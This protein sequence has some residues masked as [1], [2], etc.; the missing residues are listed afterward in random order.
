MSSHELFLLEVRLMRAALSVHHPPSPE[1]L[2]L[3]QLP[4]PEGALLGPETSLGR[5][6][7]SDE[8]GMQG[9]FP[10]HIC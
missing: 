1:G 7:G 3:M 4:C 6:G 5:K 8:M 10:L 9:L 2:C